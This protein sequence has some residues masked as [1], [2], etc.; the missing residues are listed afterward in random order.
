MHD[1]PRPDHLRVVENQQLPGRQHVAD[2]GETL[3]RDFSAAPDEQLRGAALGKREF[4]DPLVRK[5]VIEAADVD[6]SFHIL[7]EIMRQS[8][9]FL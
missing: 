6:M 9:Y 2:V 8:Y 1:D 4:G 7:P 5:V 3:F